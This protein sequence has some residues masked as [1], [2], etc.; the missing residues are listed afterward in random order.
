MVEGFEALHIQ[1]TALIVMVADKLTPHAQVLLFLIMSYAILDHVP[2][3]TLGQAI[4][5][6]QI[7]QRLARSSRYH[8]F[9]ITTNTS[10]C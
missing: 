6:K 1:P 5:S 10:F 8:K 2:R 4:S 3:G 7:L 9:S